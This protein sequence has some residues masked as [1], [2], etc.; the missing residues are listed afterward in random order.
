MKIIIHI[1]RIIFIL[2]L[3]LFI[4]VAS[5][6]IVSGFMKYTQNDLIT[7]FSLVIGL[8]IVIYIACL[9]VKE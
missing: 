2:I 1:C 7:V 8:A 4:S 6:N 9:E 3:G 5:I